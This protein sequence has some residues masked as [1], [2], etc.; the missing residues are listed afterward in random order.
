MKAKLNKNSEL[1]KDIKRSLKKNDGYCP[2]QIGRTHDTKCICK[3][4]REN[5]AVGEYCICE[6]YKKISD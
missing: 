5:V 2:C 3:D 4:F 1:V 6:L